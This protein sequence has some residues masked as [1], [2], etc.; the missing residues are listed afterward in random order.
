MPS[1]ATLARRLTRVASYFKNPWQ[2]WALTIVSTI[3]ISLTEPLVPA[4]LKPLLDT[5][6]QGGGI[7]LWTVPVALLGLFGVR[8]LCAFLG[9]IAL[10]KV[11]NQGLLKLRLAMFSRL[12]DAHPKLYKEQNASSLGNTLVY[13]VQNGANLMVNSL[14]SVSRDSLT[15]L[16]LTA[17]LIFLNWR[18]CLIV[19]FLLPAVA[20]L[21]KTTTKRLYGLT[22]SNQDA[23]DDLAYVVEENALA[24]REVRL[25]GAQESQMQRFETLGIKLNRISMKSIVAASGLTPLT[26]IMAAVALSAVISMALYQST[27]NGTTVGE[28]ASFVTAM[29]MLIAPIKHLSEVATQI[30]RGLAAIER[31]IDLMEFTPKEQT[32]SHSVLRANGE[33]KFTDVTVQYKPDAPAAL[34]SVSLD[35]ARGESIALVGTSGAGKTTL[36]NLVPRFIDITSGHITLDGV[37]LSA[38]NLSNLRQQIAMVSQNVTVLNDTLANNVALGHR[39]DRAHVLKCLHAANLSDLL[40]NLE[41]GIDTV[42]GHNASQLSGGQRQRLAI[43]RALYKDAPILILDEATSALDNESERSVQLALQELQKGRT[44]LIIAHR[45]STIEHADRIVV[46]NA[47]SI[48]EMGTHA[49]LMAAEN[50]YAKLFKIGSLG[51]T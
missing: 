38:W 22:K 25:Q 41:K 50:H 36:A 26:Q 17:Y 39:L 2:A 4:L 21:M 24:F 5:G 14:L 13:E 34:N 49:Q 45:L 29:L 1:T 23:V 12:L 19:A 30:T 10:A 31:G 3:V 44:T 20:W 6:F 48:V 8:G 40:K 16:A 18:L 27:Q 11:A 32:G 42:V 33:L 9:Q 47:G 15:L 28:F 7:P 43:A 46:M 35:I 37:D 51:S